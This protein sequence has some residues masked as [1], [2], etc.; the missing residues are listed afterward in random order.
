MTLSGLQFLYSVG[1]RW[2]GAKFEIFTAMKIPVEIFW[3]VT[4]YYIVVGYQRFGE[5]CWPDLKTGK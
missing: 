1:I 4:T 5:P 3:V 2:E